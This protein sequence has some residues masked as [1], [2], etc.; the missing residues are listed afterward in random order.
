MKANALRS[1]SRQGVHRIGEHDAVLVSGVFDVPEKTFL[2][3]PA[4]HEVGV[5]FIEL[6]D[7]GQRG[8][9]AT[10]V[11]AIIA[12]GLLIQRKN[13]FQNGG[14]VL[15][16]PDAAVEAILKQA[17][18]GRE[19]QLPVMQAAVV[20]QITHAFNQPVA[21][22]GRTVIAENGEA[23]R[24]ADEFFRIVFGVL[25]HHVEGVAGDAT[26]AFDPVHTQGLKLML[27]QRCGE[28]QQA[29]TLAEGGAEG[30][31]HG[32]TPLLLEPVCD[33]YSV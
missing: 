10:Q 22:R 19:D 26:D 32:V 27:A 33:V 20:A 21:L 14:Q 13:S 25:H 18:P 2:L 29:A 31:I 3:A 24:L 4:L 1:E 12:L 9:F 23:D 17:E 16:L 7:V 11:Q 15:V 30:Q 8:V 5:T 28:L 6:S